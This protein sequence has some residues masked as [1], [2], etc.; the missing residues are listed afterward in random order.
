MDNAKNFAKAT[1]DG[2]YDDTV[3]SVDVI[4]GDG[5]K[6]P[7]VPFNAVWWN[8]TDYPDP[9]D[10]PSVEILRVT[11]ISTDT[12][13][14]TRGDE[15]PGTPGT[16]LEHAMEGKLYRMAAGLTA[17]AVNDL[18]FSWQG[19]VF[20]IQ[21]A[22]KEVA[23]GDP[24]AEGNAT[25]F[26][27]KD[28]TGE[29]SAIG[30]AFIVGGATKLCIG[31]YASATSPGSVVKKIPIYDAGDPSTLLGYIPIYDAIT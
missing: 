18:P 16:G 31:D 19:D 3:T 10:D 4:T 2:V 14:V 30:I 12:L 27:V 13:T 22:G 20:K 15:V 24:D 21:A 6:F 8:A 5:V 17:K 29:I 26:R 7:T 1:V 23:I 9:A 25:E 11:G 28:N